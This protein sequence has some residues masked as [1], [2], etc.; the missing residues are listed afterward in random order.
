MESLDP[1]FFKLPT[2]MIFFYN[3]VSGMLI[4]KIL[5]EFLGIYQWFLMHICNAHSL[6]YKERITRPSFGEL[7][8]KCSCINVSFFKY[9]CYV[10]WQE[11]INPASVICLMKSFLWSLVT[12]LANLL[13][14][15]RKCD[16]IKLSKE[17]K[18]KSN[19]SLNVLPI[20]TLK[21]CINISLNPI[22]KSC[23]ANSV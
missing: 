16:V 12:Q 7:Y 8:R 18:L 1:I 17:K 5:Q 10:Q 20:V 19:F 15:N 2:K 9:Q 22:K 4:K 11:K 3:F 14:R 23:L 6:S 21:R 13:N